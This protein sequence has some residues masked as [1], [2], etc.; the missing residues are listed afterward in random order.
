MMHWVVSRGVARAA[1]PAELVAVP[2]G[3]GPLLAGAEAAVGLGPLLANTEPATA[4][5]AAGRG[6][7]AEGPENIQYDIP[8]TPSD[9]TAATII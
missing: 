9:K 5:V 2:T 4:P 6:V 3:S 1:A 8:A 7:S